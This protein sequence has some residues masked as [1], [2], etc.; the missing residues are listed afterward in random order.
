VRHG[1]AAEAV[2]GKRLAADT[3]LAADLER[4]AEAFRAEAGADASPPPGPLRTAIRELVAHLDRYRAYADPE[5]RLEPDGREALAEALDRARAAGRA[6]PAAL[7]AVGR[8][9]LARGAAGRPRTAPDFRARLAQLSGPVAAK[10]IEDT[11]LY[12][13]TPL[14]SLCEVGAEPDAPLARAREDFHAG[15]AERQR[16]GPWTLL[17]GS[18]HDSKRSADL[19]ARLDA[20]SECPEAWTRALDALERETAGLRTG[21]APDARDRLLVY[22]TLV[23]LWP[24]AA[25]ARGRPPGRR[26]LG[27]L[28]TRLEIVVQKSAREAKRRTSWLDPDPAYEAALARLVRGLLD[29]ARGGEALARIDRFVRG[30]LAGPGLWN[31]LARVVLQG[32][33]PGVPDLYQ[34]DELPVFQAVDPDN[35]R[36]VDFAARR[37]AL[38]A[39]SRASAATPERRRRALAAALAEPDGARAKLRVLGAVLEARRAAPALFAEGDHRPLAAEGPLADHVVAF[40]RGRGPAAAIV[41]T[42]RCGALASGDPARAPVGEAVW[43]EARLRLP[44]DL[45]SRRWRSALTGETLVGATAL[46]LARV[47]DPAPVALLLSGVRARRRP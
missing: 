39:L 29:P 42:V 23:G 19:R 4:A 21:E 13:Y 15:C 17:A 25:R 45:A 32:T 8:Q 18:S 33:A 28:A 26:D 27:E 3:L 36:P 34:G 22:Q 46:P 14:L 41:V 7:D 35:R 24:L 6:T 1:F 38:A 20:L 43:G 40:A 2:R 44:P 9:L 10:G 31:L 37:R 47:L 16:H 30:S 5:G 12:R 11:A